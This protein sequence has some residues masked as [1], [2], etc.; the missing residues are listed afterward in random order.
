MKRLLLCLLGVGASLLHAQN[1]IPNP[2]F[3]NWSAGN[4]VGW[5]TTNIL[6]VTPISQSNQS[7]S[8]TSAAKLEV[9]SVFSV[10]ISPV[11][12]CNSVSINQNY[13]TFSYYYKANLS[14]GDQFLTTAM[15][16]ENG[17]GHG[18]AVDSLSASNNSNVYVQ[19][20]VQVLYAP[21]VSQTAD[22]LTI[23]FVITGPNSSTPAI[24]SSVFLDDLNLSGGIPT[25]LAEQTA[26]LSTDLGSPQPNPA[27]G[28]C[29]IPFSL[30]EKALVQI[31]LYDLEGKLVREI[32][33][34][35]LAGGRYKAE[36][37]LSGL[38]PGLYLCKAQLHNQSYTC[39]LLVQQNQ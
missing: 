7:H 4:P 37:D 26:I 38:S 16:T 39:K 32:L 29:L 19:R 11:L 35:E 34:E 21:P 9:V 23:T 8:G 1:P 25:A 13:Q 6:T 27:S 18:A 22:M 10:A 12:I 30:K 36:C 15:L 20:N 24:G 28:N 17:N 3:E 33:H 5:T 2:G 31:G 14:G